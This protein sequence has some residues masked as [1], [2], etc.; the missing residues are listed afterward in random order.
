MSNNT[1][2][3][4]EVIEQ[5]RLNQIFGLSCTRSEAEEQVRQTRYSI[6]QFKTKNPLAWE[7]AETTATQVAEARRFEAER[8][9]RRRQGG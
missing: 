9:K 6:E 1:V 4:N 2:S 7:D 8:D 5:M 3:E